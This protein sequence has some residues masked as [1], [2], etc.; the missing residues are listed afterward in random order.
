MEENNELTDFFYF[1][2][3]I[4]Q[5]VFR[6]ASRRTRG[7]AARGDSRGGRPGQGRGRPQV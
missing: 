5:R 6:V 1:C 7:G 3:R 4:A 2:L